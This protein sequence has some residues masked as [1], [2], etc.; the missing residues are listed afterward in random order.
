M[1]GIKG[2]ADV[3]RM[4]RVFLRVDVK[5]TH[6]LDIDT[7]FQ[8]FDIESTEYNNRAFQLLAAF[9]DKVA[10]MLL[11]VLL[12]SV[13]AFSSHRECGAVSCFPPFWSFDAPP[14]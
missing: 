3:A 8:Y 2:D 7:F 4:M 6:K 14:I 12:R 13:D 10:E 11:Y 1:L 5:E 9:E